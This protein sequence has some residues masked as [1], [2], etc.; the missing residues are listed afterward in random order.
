MYAL[1]APK[2][3]PNANLASLKT[4]QA[5]PTRAKAAPKPRANNVVSLVHEP[6][7]D[8][9]HPGVSNAKLIQELNLVFWAYKIK[10][11]PE[12]EAAIEIKFFAVTP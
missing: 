2:H 1:A 4:N 3:A 7:S 11:K 8:I 6:G 10:L 12:D 5:K 9:T